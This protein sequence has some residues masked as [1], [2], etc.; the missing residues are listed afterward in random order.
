M[1]TLRPTG[2]NPTRPANARFASRCPAAAKSTAWRSALKAEE[3]PAQG[4]VALD[5]SVHSQDLRGRDLVLFLAEVEKDFLVRATTFLRKELAVR[6]LITNMNGWTNHATSQQVRSAMDFVDDHFYVDH[7]QF[8]EQPW[9]LPSRC[10]NTSP[11]AG[12][13]GGGR[14][15]A[16][17]RLLDKPFT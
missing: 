7:P 5:G 14:H 9:R 16:F 3:D 15:L 10:P 8:L 13:A 2:T 17:T 6:A 11:V 12:G 4:T 1:P